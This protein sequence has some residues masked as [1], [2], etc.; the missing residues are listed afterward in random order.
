MREKVLTLFHTNDIHSD[1][2]QWPGIVR[3]V[4]EHRTKD[5]LFLDLG[6]HADRSNPITEATEGMANMELLNI[7]GVDF[8]TIGNNEG[9]TFSKHQLDTLYEKASFPIL[10]ANLL[11]E[12]GTQPSWSIPSSIKVMEGGL[13]IGLFGVTAPLSHFYEKLGWTV[14]DLTTC[15]KKEIEKLQ[16]QVDTIILLS[17]LGLF[18]D[19]QIAEEIDGIDVIIGAHTHHVMDQGKRVGNTLIVQAGKHGHYLGEVTLTFNLDHRLTSSQATL[20]ETKEMVADPDTIQY[21]EHA[22]KRS[23]DILKQ[24]LATLPEPL[25]V[26]WYRETTATRLLCDGVTEWC[27]ESIGMMNAG[28][29]LSDLPK[30]QL[31]RGAIH[32]ICPH[33]INP[34]VIQLSGSELWTTIERASSLKLINLELKG[35]GFRGQVLGKMIYTG[36]SVILDPDD[37]E[38]VVSISVLGKPIDP[39]ASYS[40]ATLDMYTFGFLYPELTDS[41]DK[42]YLMPEFLR[43]ILAWKLNQQ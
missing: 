32:R 31:T 13:R 29:L 12:D 9:V 2:N 34:C 22:R 37:E 38:K 3:Y 5:S 27:G 23:E 14:V 19:E 39:Q 26:D 1:F 17:H 24:P 36:I 11:N 21:L 40:I 18:K 16:P 20:H 8:A 25:P 28:V 15:I 33:P 6:D 30:G 42:N 43:D 7:A 35:F 10:L 41:E 4:K